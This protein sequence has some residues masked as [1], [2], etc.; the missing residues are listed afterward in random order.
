MSDLI[1]VIHFWARLRIL[2]KRGE[3][4]VDGTKENILRTKLWNYQLININF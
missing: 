4:L 1:K 3:R 2:S